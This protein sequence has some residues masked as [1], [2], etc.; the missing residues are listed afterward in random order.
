MLVLKKSIDYLLYGSEV[1]ISV[2]CSN[3]GHP[4]KGNTL[5]LGIPLQMSRLLK[6]E[7]NNLES[8]PERL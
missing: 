1:L 8:C 7:V 3:F 4:I 2:V 6:V 5:P